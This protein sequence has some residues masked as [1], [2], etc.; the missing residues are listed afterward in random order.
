M[1][2]E[3]L[4]MDFKGQAVA[5]GGNSDDT[6]SIYDSPSNAWTNG[7]VSISISLIFLLIRH[8]CLADNAWR[9][10]LPLL[11]LGK[12][13]D[14]FGGIGMTASQSRISVFAFSFDDLF[15]AG[16]PRMLN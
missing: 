12:D 2:C 16:W 4:S 14:V 11:R 5:T 9:R 13:M 10:A 6:T 3:G 7:A 8:L 15:D 1:F